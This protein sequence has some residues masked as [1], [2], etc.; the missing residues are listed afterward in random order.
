MKETDVD[1]KTLQE[2]FEESKF[3]DAV[4]F[5]VSDDKYK[6]LFFGKF[7]TRMGREELIQYVE[8]N[9]L[10]EELYKRVVSKWEDC[11][12]SIKSNRVKKYSSQLV[13]EC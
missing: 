4:D 2:L 7:G 8:S 3:D 6:A 11:E 12:D 10:V 5:L 13:S 9:G 1:G